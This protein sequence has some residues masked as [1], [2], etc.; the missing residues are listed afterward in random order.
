MV[1]AVP[2]DQ[3]QGVLLAGLRLLEPGLGLLWRRYCLLVDRL[4]D[5]AGLYAERR[6]RAV[7][8]D[9]GDDHALD[10][11]PHIGLPAQ[12][13]VERR[14]LLAHRRGGGLGLALL[15]LVAAVGLPPL[16]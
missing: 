4:D 16:P 15:L 12:L 9:G 3:Q 5:V 7:V 1:G 10:R 2:V 13:I 8:G 6:Q 11:L 14:Q